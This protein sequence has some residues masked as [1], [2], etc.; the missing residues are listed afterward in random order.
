MQHSL[1]TMLRM[2]K[3][4]YQDTSY[5]IAA[6]GDTASHKYNAH[7]CREDKIWPLTVMAFSHMIMKKWPLIDM[8]FKCNHNLH[9]TTM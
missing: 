6:H 7:W 4:E 5:N 1:K 9:D 3:R 2:V 8:T